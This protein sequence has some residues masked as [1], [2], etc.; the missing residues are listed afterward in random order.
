MS[1]FFCIQ[2]SVKFVCNY[3]YRKKNVKI[4]CLLLF[5]DAFVFCFEQKFIP[6]VQHSGYFIIWDM[7]LKTQTVAMNTF[8]LSVMWAAQQ[9]N[10]SCS[11]N[12]HKQEMYLIILFK[13]LVKIW[14]MTWKVCI[15]RCS[16]KIKHLVLVAKR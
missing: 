3:I 8:A 5:V 12:S 14:G 1:T 4:R 2:F 13:L 9:E 16:E 7:Q 11:K 15:Y 10:N 6:T